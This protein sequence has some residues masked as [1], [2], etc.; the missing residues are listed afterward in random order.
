LLIGAVSTA[1]AATLPDVAADVVRDIAAERSKLLSTVQTT[2][3]TDRVI[4]SLI[5]RDTPSLASLVK[6]M[7]KGSPVLRVNSAGILAKIGSPVMD[8]DVV[9]AL[10]A[11]EESRHLYLTAVASRV[12]SVP[13]DDAGQIVSRTQPLQDASHVAAF[14]AEVANPYDSGS[15][16]CSTLVLARTRPADP[17]AIDDA[18]GRALKTETSREILRSI[19][20][21]LAGLD[22]LTV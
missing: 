21:T 8:D 19:A 10:K 4:G 17:R 6:W 9:R 2:H 11:D 7:N 13:W 22:P 5:A 12:L 3:T 15:R 16:W 20:G 1:V 18:L 14:A